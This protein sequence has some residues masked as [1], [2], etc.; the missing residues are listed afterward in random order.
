M[1]NH[2]KI[3]RAARQAAPKTGSLCVVNIGSHLSV[4]LPLRCG[5]DLVNILARAM[6]VEHKFNARNEEY[7]ESNQIGDTVLVVIKAEQIIPRPAK[8]AP[9]GSG[10]TS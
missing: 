2:P 3:V 9:K 6:V 10:V 4:A 8:M 5:T 7:F 1:I